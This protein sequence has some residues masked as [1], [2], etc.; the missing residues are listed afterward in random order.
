MCQVCLMCDATGEIES[1]A[2]AGGDG[3]ERICIKKRNLPVSNM[4]PLEADSE[5]MQTVIKGLF[6]VSL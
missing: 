1:P 3:A 6:Y 2:I 4:L 5:F